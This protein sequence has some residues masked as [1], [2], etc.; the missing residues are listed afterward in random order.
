[1]CVC[2]GSLFFL[3]DSH[4]HEEGD[5]IPCCKTQP[6]LGAAAAPQPHGTQAGLA[7]P[8]AAR[9]SDPQLHSFKTPTAVPGVQ[10]W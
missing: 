8:A 2:F 7:V 9:M 5:A 10:F 6:S 1:M 4:G 3:T